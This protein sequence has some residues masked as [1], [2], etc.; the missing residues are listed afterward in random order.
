M[1]LFQVYILLTFLLN[2]NLMSENRRESAI[3]GGG[4]YW[5][6]E[7]VYQRVKGVET[8]ESGFS[9]GNVKNPSYRE[10]CSGLTGHAEVVRVTFNPDI[11]SYEQLLMIFFTIHDP[12]T[13][14]RQGNDIGTQ[15]RSVIFYTKES[16]KETAERVMKSISEE[17][18]FDAPLVTQ[19]LPEEPFYKAEDYHRNYYNNNKEQA[20]CRVVVAPKVAK[21]R[22]KHAE[23]IKNE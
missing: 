10:V 5:C 18:I 2:N 11:I 22:A 8:I 9:G 13:L 14:N 15:Y 3:L 17:G 6:L 4:C 23:W 19:L 21:F 7:A 12:T 1:K 16:Q 20:Y